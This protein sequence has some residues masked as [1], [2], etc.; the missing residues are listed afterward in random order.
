VLIRS[1][2]ADDA[3]ALVALY[4]DWGHPQPAA[5]I[6]GRLAAWE[7]TPHGRVLVAELDYH[8][9]SER[10]ARYVRAL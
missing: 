10:Q 9:A 5:V 2:H 6:A 7:A 1:A 3:P 4:A 8:D